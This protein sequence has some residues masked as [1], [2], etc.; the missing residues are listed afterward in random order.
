MLRRVGWMD[1][2]QVRA[3]TSLL[4]LRRN[5]GGRSEEEMKREGSME[6]DSL[7]PF[8]D[9]LPTPFQT[10]SPPETAFLIVYDHHGT[11]LERADFDLGGWAGLGTRRRGEMLSSCA[12]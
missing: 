12:W 7:S 11:Y 4:S 8:V 1:R 3:Y 9:T 6:A 10:P 5:V 2:M